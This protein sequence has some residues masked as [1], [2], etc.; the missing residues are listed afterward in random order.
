MVALFFIA[1]DS[2][3]SQSTSL[4]YYLT[5]KGVINMTNKTDDRQRN[6]SSQDQSQ[7]QNMNQDDQALSQENPNS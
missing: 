6:S 5:R 3:I 4:N 2:N 1:D 7:D